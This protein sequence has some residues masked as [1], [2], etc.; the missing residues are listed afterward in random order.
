MAQLL[1]RQDEPPLL[2]PEIETQVNEQ[3]LL[4]LSARV[5]SGSYS[6]SMTAT[7]SYTSLP[8][9][10]SSSMLSASSSYATASLQDSAST[11]RRPV[12][13][14]GRRIQ[15][16]DEDDH[17]LEPR[18][19]SKDAAL[20]QQR[21]TP[22]RC[23]GSSMSPRVAPSVGA[24]PRAHLAT[25]SSAVPLTG[26]QAFVR[27]L[28]S[29]LSLMVLHVF[30]PLLMTLT[31]SALGLLHSGEEA[32]DNSIQGALNRPIEKRSKEASSRSSTAHRRFTEKFKTIVCT[33]YLLTSSLS[34][35]FYESDPAPQQPSPNLDR[36]LSED[37]QHLPQTRPAPRPVSLSIP[38]ASCDAP[39]PRP[40]ERSLRA[41]AGKTPRADL[42]PRLSPAGRSVRDATVLAVAVLAFLTKSWDGWFRLSLALSCLSWASILTLGLAQLDD[43]LFFELSH[44]PSSP[45]SRP[46]FEARIDDGLTPDEERAYER[47][48]LRRVK[49]LVKSAQA[50][51]ITINKCI[52]AVQEVELVSRGYKLTHPLPP[53]SRIEATAAAAA[54]AST[55]GAAWSS[56]GS[57][58]R[59]RHSILG[60]G[61]A[62]GARLSRSSSTGTSAASNRKHAQRPLSLSLSTGRASPALS[63][64]SHD[65]ADHFRRPFAAGGEQGQP[66]APHPRRLATLRRA[67]LDSLDQVAI[68]CKDANLELEQLADGEELS[69]LKDMYALDASPVDAGSEGDLTHQE[70]TSISS[71]GPVTE[72]DRPTAW[73]ATLPRSAAAA[74]ASKRPS[75]DLARTGSL[76]SDDDG[77]S[78]GV[79][80]PVGRKRL[81]LLS[82]GLPA[83]MGATTP[84]P[85]YDRAAGASSSASKRE[86]LISEG[87]PSTYRSPRLSYVT[88]K[89]ATPGPNESAAS[90]R[91]SYIS[92]SSAAAS[93][94]PKSPVSN[95]SPFRA[96]SPFG[97]YASPSSRNGEARS[98]RTSIVGPNSI[99]GPTAPPEE[100]LDPQTLLGLKNRFERMHLAR[101]RALCHLLALEFPQTEDAIGKEKKAALD[102]ADCWEL[103][104]RR[105]AD[106][107]DL[108]AREARAAMATLSD[109]MGM[110]FGTALATGGSGKRSASG[111]GQS[112]HLAPPSVSE[113]DGRAASRASS[114][115]TGHLGLEDRFSA[116]A[117]SLRSVQAKLRVCAED[118][119]VKR[120]SELHGLE[121]SGGSSGDGGAAPAT[122]TL[123][124]EDSPALSQVDRVQRMFESIKDDLL[125]LSAEWEA[126]VKFFKKEKR[127]TPSPA[128][129]EGDEDVARINAARDL[130]SPMEADE[131]AARAGL[132]VGV[133]ADGTGASRIVYESGG[134]VSGSRAAG[135]G[136]EDDDDDDDDI[137]AL[138]LRST[139]PQHLPPP[140]L[141]QVFE[142]IAGMASIA[143][144]G[145]SKLSRD[146]RIRQAKLRRAEEQEEK[147]KK[148]SHRHTIDPA[149]I[150]SELNDVIRTRKANVERNAAAAGGS[151]D[152]SAQLGR[153]SLD[154]K[155][156]RESSPSA[157]LGSSRVGAGQGLGSPLDLRASATITGV[158]EGNNGDG[159]SANWSP[160]IDTDAGSL[161]TSSRRASRYNVANERRASTLYRHL[162]RRSD[163]AA[164][165]AASESFSP[166]VEQPS[167]DRL[168][169]SLSS[170]SSA[171]TFLPASTSNGRMSLDAVTALNGSPSA[172][173]AARHGAGGVAA[174]GAR[175]ASFAQTL[176]LDLERHVAEFAARQKR[177]ASAVGASG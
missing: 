177:Q 145:G 170:S 103:P 87:Q 174:E 95:A 19:S 159:G 37:A 27:D 30:F 163:D 10:H 116:M 128:L 71:I 47:E 100:V 17:D 153:A 136:A 46:L 96:G 173:A 36:A 45:G 132:G 34:I 133:D 129:F 140:G 77:W 70:D 12:R 154:A 33:S 93:V 109:E 143:G 8:R 98:N 120:P 49:A 56:L 168:P 68:G 113:V 162:H 59:N 157:G 75:V 50:Y 28:Q 16:S 66:A 43:V 156:Y 114:G 144:I 107:A 150:V 40:S 64:D 149:G 122:A 58:S 91:L 57:P 84:G 44:I 131:D 176:D 161:S 79:V 167:R 138:L 62:Q 101:R 1:D 32:E 155:R 106:L 67:V 135:A 127:S 137:A 111:E 119:N 142:S 126:G 31:S 83:A 26:A 11:P 97:L 3:A 80:S 102:V 130:E 20:A 9:Q 90:K 146:E 6:P 81:S 65:G 5:P 73:A 88:E 74:S 164:D 72:H 89:S 39:A 55:S 165:G 108:F 48:A 15:Q 38:A 35:S 123:E 115:I 134:K 52:G 141:E 151:V 41:G 2:L 125:A 86:S 99:F 117:L 110:A 166:L 85:H 61:G 69:L 148:Q 175:P 94:G 21:A 147:A 29:A 25:T 24:S 92:A 18:P 51:D 121:S 152:A 7:S 13:R 63:S 112:G 54:G 172:M 76:R 53:I 104:C 105:M 14:P 4:E 160:A 60:L 82:D 169:P 158:F 118:I 171:S 78:R 124:A 139:S 22:P 42:L 23:P